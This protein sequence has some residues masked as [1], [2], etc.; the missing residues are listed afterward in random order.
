MCYHAYN[1]GG[2]LRISNR[3]TGGL[4]GVPLKDETVNGHVHGC[5]LWV[6]F[7]CPFDDGTVA[8]VIPIMSQA[9]FRSNYR[10]WPPHLCGGSRHYT[11]QKQQRALLLR[12]NQKEEEAIQPGETNTMS[13]FLLSRRSDMKR[14]KEGL[15]RDYLVQCNTTTHNFHDGMNKHHCRYIYTHI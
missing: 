6:F 2:F 9:S 13:C 7:M 10:R 15:M 11:T 4:L 14:K 1:M 3:Q 5:T 12:G 8:R